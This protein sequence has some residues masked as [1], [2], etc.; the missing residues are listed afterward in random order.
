[1]RAGGTKVGGGSE[2][3]VSQP[4]GEGIEGGG[5]AV[6]HRLKVGTG[7]MPL[8][9]CY[10]SGTPISWV[11]LAYF[12]HLSSVLQSYQSLSR[13]HASR[14]ALLCPSPAL[15]VGA[16]S[17]RAVLG[18]VSGDALGVMDGDCQVMRNKPA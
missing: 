4:K 15:F 11:L 5:G 2:Q 16:A 14:P 8:F 3:Q 12:T 9:S 18:S 6:G 7:F 17:C 1:M 13:R 10:F